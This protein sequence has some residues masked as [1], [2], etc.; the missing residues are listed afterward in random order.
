M[1]FFF[2]LKQK[3]RIFQ[4]NIKKKSWWINLNLEDLFIDTAFKTKLCNIFCDQE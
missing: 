2:N 1:T 3:S 4:R